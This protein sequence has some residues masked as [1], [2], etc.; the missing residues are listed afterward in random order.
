MKILMKYKKGCI[1]RNLFYFSNFLVLIEAR[2]IASLTSSKDIVPYN[3]IFC[4]D[5]CIPKSISS[6]FAPLSCPTNPEPI[7]IEAISSPLL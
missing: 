2:L 4:I 3:E 6:I 5:S 1:Y 7:S